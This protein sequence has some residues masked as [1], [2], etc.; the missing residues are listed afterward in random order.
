MVALPGIA[1]LY[2]VLL[3]AS[4]PAVEVI[5][6]ADISAMSALDTGD[7]EKRA[8]TWGLGLSR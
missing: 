2:S 1:E 7:G 3:C 6:V 4:R 8:P 5:I